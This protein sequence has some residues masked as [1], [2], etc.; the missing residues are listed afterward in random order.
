MDQKFLQ[1]GM[2]AMSAGSTTL[3]GWCLGILGATVAGIVAG[4]FLRLT[5]IGRWV[6]LLFIPGWVC[7]GVSIWYGDSV[8]RRL[9]AAGFT[10]NQERLEEIA[11]SMNSDYGNQREW[12]QF[13]LLTFGIWLAFFLVWWAFGKVEQK[14]TS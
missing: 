14:S 10:G 5:G 7:L 11:T 13:A 12:F 3:T 8:A 4:N 1:D 9:A 6:Y 2:S